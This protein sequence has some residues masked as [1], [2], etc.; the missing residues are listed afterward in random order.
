VIKAGFGATFSRWAKFS[1]RIVS[2]VDPAPV[3]LY[4][5]AISPI[6]DE[7]VSWPSS[8]RADTVSMIEELRPGADSSGCFGARLVELCSERPDRIDWLSSAPIGAGAVNGVGDCGSPTGL[9]GAKVV[10]PGA[11]GLKDPEGEAMRPAA[12]GTGKDCAGGCTA[13]DAMA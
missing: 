9:N 12:V 6:K 11:A 13:R 3:E 1:K 10:C 8:K 7:D 2:C 5:S 4:I